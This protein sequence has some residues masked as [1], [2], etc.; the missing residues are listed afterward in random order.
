MATRTA[1]GI[2]GRLVDVHDIEGNLMYR[3]LIDDGASMVIPFA[4]GYGFVD[5]LDVRQY[6]W[7]L[8]PHDEAGWDATK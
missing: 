8:V 2:T 6:G 7:Q 4:S 1:H 5:R 3:R